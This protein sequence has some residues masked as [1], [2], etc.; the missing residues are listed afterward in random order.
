MTFPQDRLA[1]NEWIVTAP[2]ELRA[3]IDAF[4]GSGGSRLQPEDS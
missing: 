4:C 2:C 1:G 3:V